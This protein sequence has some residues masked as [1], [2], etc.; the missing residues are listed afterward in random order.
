MKVEGLFNQFCAH[1]TLYFKKNVFIYLAALG[2]NCSM[3][4][5]VP[6]SGI[7]HGCLHWQHYVLATGPPGK[8]L[9]TVLGSVTDHRPPLRPPQS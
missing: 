9:I 6:Q 8:S 7:E 1:H 3:W 4:D 5:L 2:L